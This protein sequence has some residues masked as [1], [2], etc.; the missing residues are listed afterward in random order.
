VAT[1][2]PLAAQAGIEMLLAGGNAVDAA[3]ATAAALTVV[4][5]TSNGIGGDA[6]ALVWDGERL[7]GLNGSGRA[8]AALTVAAVRDAGHESMPRLGWQSVTVPGVPAAWNDLHTRFGR[9]PFERVLAPAVRLAREGY[10][11]APVSA[12][13]W[14]SAARVFLRLE[15]PQF[16]AWGETFAPG[17]KAPQAG[18][19]MRLTDHAATLEAIARSGARDF[20]E[21]ALARAIATF[22]ERS[23]GTLTLGDLATHQSTWVDPVST[24]YRGYRVHEIPPN[25][26]G[27][28]ALNALNILESLHLGRHARDSD[29]AYHLQIECM[30]LAMA[31]ADAWVADPERAN[32]PSA[33]LLDKAYAN[34]RR[35]LIGETARVQPPGDPPR[36]G[37]VYLCS[38]DGDGM[39]VSFIQSNF[40]GFGSGVVVPGT[41]IALQN[42]G[43]GFTLKDG[44]PN[45]LAPG[46]RPFHTIIPGF[47]TAGGEAVG[48]FG[49]MG[50]QMQPQGHLQ[51]VVNTVDYG[52]NPQS[53]L[54]APRWRWTEGLKVELERAVPEQ[55]ALA[56]RRRGHDAVV[57]VDPA[58]FGRGQIIWRQG[59]TLVAASDPRADGQALAI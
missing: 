11:V 13:Y 34:Q 3:V 12:R 37:T 7:H 48:P 51:V 52:M 10:P 8:P 17:G 1:S 31:D 27:I 23:G 28:A 2:Q 59:R 15:G 56:L 42:R 54:D 38:A 18:E 29:E 36:G 39:M 50:G 5:P 4:E 43:N 22:A 47:L 58:G 6:F 55:V 40:A 25:G 46:K 35:R 44:H 32:V 14:R 21:G 30:K 26:Q 33:G 24:D 19:V 41:G 53:A 45:Q 16:A 20:Y 57:P 49:V 9:L